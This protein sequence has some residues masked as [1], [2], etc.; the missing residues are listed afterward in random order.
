MSTKW[1]FQPGRAVCF[2][3]RS[4]RCSMDGRGAGGVLRVEGRPGAE[5]TET[6]AR[7]VR[8]GGAATARARPWFVGAPGQASG[9]AHAQAADV[10]AVGSPPRPGGSIR[11]SGAS[12]PG[13]GGQE[14]GC[15]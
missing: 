4:Q 9:S 12:G 11:N 7:S 3:H 8:L 15:P 6:V 10:M 5:L 1:V 2:R 14:E 13:G